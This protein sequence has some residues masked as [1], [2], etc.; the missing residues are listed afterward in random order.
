MPF[1]IGAQIRAHPRKSD[2]DPFRHQ[3]VEEIA[4]RS[5]GR[6]VEIGNR[7]RVYNEPSYRRWRGCDERA[8]L[9]GETVGVGVEEIGPKPIDDESGL[10]L[11]TWLGR[12]GR[13][14]TCGVG[15]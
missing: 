7:A 5:G 9:A 15:D 1:E 2:V 6:V 11:G 12:R 13:P 8:S 14:S 4:N 10:R 3:L